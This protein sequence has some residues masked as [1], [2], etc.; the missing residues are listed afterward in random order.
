MCGVWI[1][2]PSFPFVSELVEMD[3]HTAPLPSRGECVG[4][5]AKARD[6]RRGGGGGRGRRGQRAAAIHG[7]PGALGGGG[8]DSAV[9]FCQRHDRFRV[10]IPDYLKILILQSAQE[11]SLSRGFGRSRRAHT[12]EASAR[13]L[14]LLRRLIYAHSEEKETRPWIYRRLK[15]AG[16]TAASSCPSTSAAGSHPWSIRSQNST[17][18]VL[19]VGGD[20][21]RGF[22][23]DGECCGK[24]LVLSSRVLVG[25]FSS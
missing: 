12:Y 5:R 19:K 3:P 8:R 11:T 23:H 18:G 1:W 20:E 17:R 22:G 10:E 25:T 6:G 14:W 15:V 2:Q 7:A 16:Q 4:L 9:L 13:V 24:P 21:S